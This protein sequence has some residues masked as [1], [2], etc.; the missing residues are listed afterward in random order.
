MIAAQARAIAMAWSPPD[1]PAGWRLTAETFAAIAKDDDVRDLAVEI[2]LDRLPPLLLSAAVA[3]LVADRQPHPLAGYY[4]RPG[5]AQPP[6][7]D[8]FCDA[9]REFCRA[10]QVALAA[11]RNASI[12]DER[13]GPLP[14]CAADAGHGQA[15]RPTAAR[16]DRPRHRRRAWAARRPVRIPLPARRRL[17]AHRWRPGLAGAAAVRRP[18]GANPTAARPDA[19][20]RRP[21]RHRCRTAGHAE[22]QTRSWLAACV[23]PEARAVT[24]FATAAALAGANPARSVRG[25]LVDVLGDV[26]TSVAADA[27]VCLVDTYVHVFLPPESLQRFHQLI[28]ALGRRRDLEWISVD[29]AEQRSDHVVT[30]NGRRGRRRLPLSV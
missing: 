30:A 3:F 16:A 15:G 11:V 26:V 14:G 1:A 5:S 29:H 12:P 27:L 4:P 6:Y 25:D 23:P 28:D 19:H 10:E 2:P 22:Q 17:A 9:L 21:V 18:R 20:D 13:D 8:S 24:R 7:D